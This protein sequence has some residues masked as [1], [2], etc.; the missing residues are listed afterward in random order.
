MR[1]KPNKLSKLVQ[2][3]KAPIRILCK[4]RDFY[5]KGILGFAN[6]GNV[7]CGSIGGGATDLPKSYS[8]NSLRD[9]DD[10][11]FKKL[12]RLLSEKGTETESYM[13]S[14]E[15]GDW[16]SCSRKASAM[17]RNYS[18]GVGKI[19]RI[20]EGRACSFREEEDDVNGNSYS[21]S[22]SHAVRRNVVYY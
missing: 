13:Q 16:R 3:T 2:I 7:G 17:R 5:V 18:V 19:G 12:L 6:S 14:S 15:Q 10:E 8:V 1:S 9:V 11:E 21:R 22:R 20:D 4:A